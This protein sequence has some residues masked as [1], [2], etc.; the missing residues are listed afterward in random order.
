MAPHPAP[1]G[2]PSLQHMAKIRILVVEDEAPIALNLR[3]SLL[4][5]GYAVGAVAMNG[6]EAVQLVRQEP[7]DLVLMDV[8]LGPGLDGIATAERMREAHPVPVI[9]LTAFAT[10]HTLERASATEPYGYLIKPVT[11]RELN[12]S[13]KMALARHRAELAL[14]QSERELRHALAAQ[15]AQQSEILELNATLAHANRRLAHTAATDALTGLRN[16][17]TFDERLGEELS[18][19]RRMAAPLSLLMIDVDHFKSYND[20]YGHPA[21]DQALQAVARAFAQ[22]ARAS[23]LVTRY[24]GEEFAVILPNTGAAPA[25]ELAAR[26]RVAVAACDWEHAPLTVS[27]GIATLE[28]DAGADAADL[29]ARADRALYAAKNAGRDRCIQAASA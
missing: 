6:E 11:E 14:E 8:H 27:M 5:L 4:T 24:G 2:S 19:M 20:S 21:G 26:V 28:P 29:V 13:V 12:A 16:R 15:A 9:Y 7:P 25:A 1:T 22:S 23:D 18:L 10:D 3:E 17:R